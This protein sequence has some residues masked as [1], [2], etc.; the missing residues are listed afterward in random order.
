MAVRGRPGRAE[1]HFLDCEGLEDNGQERHVVRR[2]AGVRGFMMEDVVD[3]L[4]WVVVVVSR[5][6]E[7]DVDESRSKRRAQCDCSMLGE[8]VETRV[9]ECEDRIGE[10]R[11]VR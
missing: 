10:L 6:L 7:V 9:G 8:V 3:V 2:R 11:I 4:V 5:L 1:L